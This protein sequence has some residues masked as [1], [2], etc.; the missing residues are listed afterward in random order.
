MHKIVSVKEVPGS[1][2][3]PIWKGRMQ[4]IETDNGIYIDNLTGIT[5]GGFLGHN[6]STE[7]GNTINASV[8][9]SAGNSWLKYESN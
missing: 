3:N 2:Y 9:L 1:K 7:I 5:Y 4:E 6:W 8:I